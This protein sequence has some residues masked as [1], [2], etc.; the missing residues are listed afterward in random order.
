MDD[1]F[2]RV[3]KDFAPLVDGGSDRDYLQN[4]PIIL[5][6]FFYF[7]MNLGII[8]AVWEG[9]RH[10]G[11]WQERQICD[12][13]PFLLP[14]DDTRG[15]KEFYLPLI[16]YL[17]AFLNFFMVIPRSWTNIESQG[18]IQQIDTKA[19]PTATDGRFKAGCFFLFLAWVVICY[20]LTH[21]F[22]YYKPHIRGSEGRMR[23]FIAY[24]PVRFLIV[25]PLCLVIIGY[26]F[27]TAWDFEI[28]PLKFD[29]N[30]GWIYG[31]GYAPVLL[32]SFIF[33]LHGALSENED[34]QILAQRRDRERQNDDTLGLHKKPKWWSREHRE[35][36]TTAES[37]LKALT[38][39][40]G[41]GAPT[42]RNI[43]SA[44][45]MG[46]ISPRK[47]DDDSEDILPDGTTSDG[48]RMELSL[49]HW[50]RTPSERKASSVSSTPSTTAQ[51][52]PTKIRSM[53]DV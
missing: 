20:D 6:S 39:E 46:N 45:E 11:S 33:Q 12:R 10:W 16:F 8:A 30:P 15:K 14:Q 5:Q 13:D 9:V 32:I 2:F 52:Q 36:H 53:L 31:L 43:E 25:L 4:L 28:S 49:T 41:G 3:K 22:H 47:H 18:S 21:I 29:V 51:M 1:V 26:S 42:Q 40:I 23:G 24:T 17:L 50:S 34:R 19:R 7:L 37:R 35:H 48:P 38:T 27:A 44:L